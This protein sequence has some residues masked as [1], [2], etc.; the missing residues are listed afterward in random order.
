MDRGNGR[1]EL[2]SLDRGCYFQVWMW[3][4]DCTFLTYAGDQTSLAHRLINC[5]HRQ[6]RVIVLWWV[7]QFIVKADLAMI[8][9]GIA[10]VDVSRSF[11]SLLLP[12]RWLPLD[13][14]TC[15]LRLWKWRHLLMLLLV[16]WL[17]EEPCLR[18]SSCE[19][20]VTCVI[21][22]VLRVERGWVAS[23]VLHFEGL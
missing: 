9:W 3:A 20:D 23:I 22:D 17:T 5:L 8:R 12:Q 4:E 21:V 2:C 1:S 6:L 19:L 10:A 16:H 13:F 7:L 11:Q 18:L 15:M 14:S